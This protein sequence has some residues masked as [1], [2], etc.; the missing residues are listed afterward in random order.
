[1]AV[2]EIGAATDEHPITIEFGDAEVIDVDAPFEA[3]SVTKTMV[4]VVALQLVDEGALTLDG[5]LPDVAG[6]PRATTENLTLR[7]LL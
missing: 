1:M 5:P 6:I 4:A 3:L 2:V 7:R